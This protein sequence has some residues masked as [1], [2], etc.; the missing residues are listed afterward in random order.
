MGHTPYGYKIEN[1]AAFIDEEKANRIQAFFKEYLSGLSLSAAAKKAGINAY[2]GTAGNMLRNKKYLGDGFYPAIV[3]K[4][5]FKQAEIERQ[6]RARKLG[7]VYES[8]EQEKPEQDFD[9]TIGSI[10]EDYEDPFTQAEY[11][12]GLIRRKERSNDT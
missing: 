9:F 11:V 6:K 2:H 8:K 7:R 3:D 10:D 1:G 5:T 12:Y 4:E